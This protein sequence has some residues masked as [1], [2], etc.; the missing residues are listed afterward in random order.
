M[1]FSFPSNHETS[2]REAV[3]YIVLLLSIVFLPE[4]EARAKRVQTPL[5][6]ATL[7]VQALSTDDIGG[8]EV[9]VTT[10]EDIGEHSMDIDSQGRIFVAIETMTG[11]NPPEVQVYR[12]VDAGDSWELWGQITQ[13]AGSEY[14]FQGPSIHVAEGV[15][16]AVFVAITYRLVG[17]PRRRIM[18][19][20]SDLELPTASF[21]R[22][23][24]FDD[25]NQGAGNVHL[26]SDEAFFGNY[27][28]Y[29]AFE[30][31]DGNGT[32][33]WFARSVDYGH[34][35]ESPYAL[36]LVS[37]AYYERP[38]VCFSPGGYVHVAWTHRCIMTTACQYGIR[39]R[40]ASSFANAG[41]S[42]WGP[43]YS[44][45]PSQAGLH[46]LNPTVA[47]DDGT[48]VLI[49][50]TVVNDQND[51]HAP[52]ARY[53]WDSGATWSPADIT[54]LG[55]PGQFP[56]AHWQ[57]TPSKWCV[58]SL[59][60]YD[61]LT[62]CETAP[63][64]SP[65]GWSGPLTFSD[66]SYPT[67]WY[68][69]SASAVD[70]THDD[71]LAMI[72]RVP[73]AEGGTDIL[74]FDAE[75]RAGPGYPNVED[76][77]PT[78]LGDSNYPVCPIALVDLGGSPAKEIVFGDAFGDVHV[79]Q[80]N[81]EPLPGWPID[82]RPNGPVGVAIGDLNG[83][84]TLEVVVGTTA[85][86]V[87]AF[88][89]NGNLMSGW[90]V[91][92]PGHAVTHVSIGAL[93]PPYPRYVL[94]ASG[95]DVFIF[96]YRGEEVGKYPV[97]TPVYGPV[98]I[99][100]VDDDGI[101]EFVT[102]E[103]RKVQVFSLASPIPRWSFYHASASF[104]VPAALGDL[105][106]DGDLEIVTAGSSGRAMVFHHDFVPY[107]GAWPVT[108]GSGRLLAPALANVVGGSELE[109][110]M[111]AQDGTVV[112]LLGDG[113]VQSGYPRSVGPPVMSIG[114]APIF[115]RVNRFPA[116]A[117]VGHELL[118]YSWDN[119]GAKGPGWPKPLD[120]VLTV[121]PACGD[122]DL[123]GRNEF[124][125][126]GVS[127]LIV[128]DV[129]Y[130]ATNDPFRNWPMSGHD[131]QRTNCLDCPENI[132]TGIPGQ[133]EL[134]RLAFRVESSNPGASSFVFRYELPYPAAVNLSIYDVRGRLLRRLTK[135]EL[136]AGGYSVEWD[137]RD[138]KGIQV[139]SG[140]YY[141]RLE[142]TGAVRETRVRKLSVLR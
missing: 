17:D 63:S 123:D 25:A 66:R 115:G 69:G 120:A 83:D 12:S 109:I 8:D 101:S 44:L 58:S 54:T 133:D 39:Y 104:C 114:Q 26:T 108:V 127:Q 34:S 6:L 64:T 84:E 105:D 121:G 29:L 70:P 1:C 74:Y 116:N 110:V 124:V 61:G 68:R 118:A 7:P 27:Y 77:Y 126:G 128:V 57:G 13:G 43:I 76:G 49:S 88:S 90:P 71:Q 2:W 119:F 82:L 35:W 106:L 31:S 67:P 42:S 131:P 96:N 56:I 62:G 141:A 9:V 21:V 85:S 139:A 135:S 33:I 23:T 4:S 94:A 97:D 78:P 20:R 46:Y 102:V 53:S 11:A 47:A 15:E 107:P 65:H 103:Q 60:R 37:T 111:A 32:D 137:G 36:G 134:S 113:T 10:H 91:T 22:V 140:S 86:Q 132:A 73:D 18:V 100:D 52:L 48:S 93:G 28:L 72:W 89:A 87:F 142:V 3:T 98:S 40:R 30:V 129:N 14:F 136:G 112:L 122:I 19:A 117:A 45:D 99:G 79:V 130:P 59:A 95:L 16:D 24:A 5:G 75:W 81:R 125:F 50:H 92:L 55:R 41:S 80:H 38:N 138:R 51:F